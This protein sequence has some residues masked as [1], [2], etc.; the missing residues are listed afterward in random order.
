M[1]EAVVVWEGLHR[2]RLPRVNEWH[3]AHTIRG[4][5]RIFE[6]SKYKRDKQAAAVSFSAVRPGKPIDYPVDC[7][8]VVSIWKVLDTD[9]PIKGIMDALELGGILKDD[10]QIRHL[11]VKRK[12][13]KRDTTDWCIVQLF[14]TG[15]E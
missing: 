11:T 1:N 15:V 14:R 5:A 4:K 7:T 6:G 10:R 2:G 3:G 12:Y 13:H 9:A 8:I